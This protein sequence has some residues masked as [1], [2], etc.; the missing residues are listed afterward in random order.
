MSFIKVEDRRVDTRGIYLWLDDYAGSSI[1]VPEFKASSDY[2]LQ[3]RLKIHGKITKKV[4]PFPRTKT[5]Y[6]AIESVNDKRLSLIEKFK[7]NGTLK[8]KKVSPV[9]AA[10]TFKAKWDK[11]MDRLELTARPATIKNYTHIYNN[12]LSPFGSY[13]EVTVEDMQNLVKKMISKGKAASTIRNA[14][15]APK[16][17]LNI[18]WS[19][20]S[21]PDLPEQRTFKWPIEDSMKLVKAM[22]SYTDDAIHNKGNEMPSVFEFLLRGRRINEVLTLKRSDIDL[23]RGVYTIRGE[24]SKG[25]TSIEYPLDDELIAKIPDGTSKF[26]FSV[27]LTTVHRHFKKI[28]KEQEL[29]WL[30]VHDIRHLTATIA[31]ESGVAIADVSRM[32][33]HKRI[34]TTEDRYVHKTTKMAAR[35]SKGF[36]DAVKGAS[37]D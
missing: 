8:D 9:I 5:L 6:K 29:P 26:L 22:R 13:T 16:V 30:H 35:A 37:D 10:D 14:L 33:G 3:I 19:E 1:D 23:P 18:N 7:L 2:K 17:F 11:Y 34:S 28:L 27:S 36:L 15:A 21:V 24:N 32:L 31:L 12:W 4:F 20:V 25:K